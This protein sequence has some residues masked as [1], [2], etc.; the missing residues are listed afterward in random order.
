MNAPDRL[1]PI[2]LDVFQ[3]YTTDDKLDY[4][5]YKQTKTPR[6]PTLYQMSKQVVQIERSFK[7]TGT[8][9]ENNRAQ[10]VRES[11]LFKASNEPR[12][13]NT[14]RCRHV[15]THQEILRLLTI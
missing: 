9:V 2:P 4:L 10:R 5:N 7:L 14:V 8:R 11:V 3:K 13:P 15:I 6:F 1:G 12:K